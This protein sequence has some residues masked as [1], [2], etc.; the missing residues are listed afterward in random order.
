MIFVAI[1]GMRSP[2]NPYNAGV[3]HAWLRAAAGNS[4]IVALF[5]VR[6]KQALGEA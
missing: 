2:V 3:G 4:E 6:H 5:R 1:A